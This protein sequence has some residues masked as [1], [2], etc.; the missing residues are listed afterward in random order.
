MAH[1][2][3]ER[4]HRRVWDAWHRGLS[5]GRIT[6]LLPTHKIRVRTLIGSNGGVRPPPQRRA[7]RALS[8]EEREW[9]GK[10]LAV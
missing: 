3:R 4:L 9:I 1:Y 10:G 7:I 6:R 2:M 8:T 5:M